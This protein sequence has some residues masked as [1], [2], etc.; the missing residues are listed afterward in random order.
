MSTQH[1]CP[2][3]QQIV[4]K[5]ALE[6]ARV[7]RSGHK[8]NPLEDL[9]REIGIMRKMRHP[10]IVA[11]REVNR[12]ASPLPWRSLQHQVHCKCS[13]LSCDAGQSREKGACL[14]GLARA[15]VADQTP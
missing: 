11:L 1:A 3:I 12:R 15:T 6:A 2:P 13:F 4:K 7:G 14:M 5:V 9:R 10:N 8:R